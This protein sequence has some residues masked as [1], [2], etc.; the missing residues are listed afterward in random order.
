MRVIFQSFANCVHLFPQIADLVDAVIGFGHFVSNFDE[1]S[2]LLLQVGL[3]YSQARIGFD[4]KGRGVAFAQDRELHLICSGKRTRPAGAAAPEGRVRH[5]AGAFVIEIPDEA[6]QSGV[7]GKRAGVAIGR[8]EAFILLAL[9]F[10]LG[11]VANHLA[12]GIEDVER[13][14]GSFSFGRF[15]IGFCRGFFCI[16]GLCRFL[17]IAVFLFGFLLVAVWLLQRSFQPIVDDGAGGGILAGIGTAAEERT[18]K[19]R[20]ICRTRCEQMCGILRHGVAVLLERC[21][22]VKHPEA[23]AVRGDN[24]VIVFNNEIVHR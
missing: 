23:A 7:G 20:V 9:L 24:Q 11:E 3:R 1:Q 2:E 21:D 12:R 6:V 18:A 15:Y 13:N 5:L 4:L 16:C 10:F 22:V 8:T 14:L 19:Q 17:G